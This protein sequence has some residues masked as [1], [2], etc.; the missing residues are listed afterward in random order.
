MIRLG[1]IDRY[2]EEFNTIAAFKICLVFW[3][4]QIVI[5]AHFKHTRNPTAKSNAS[6]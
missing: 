2:H 1:G 3:G 6:Y 4:V 5:R